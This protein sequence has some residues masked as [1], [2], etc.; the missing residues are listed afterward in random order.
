MS[1][2]DGMLDDRLKV[3]LD[4]Y[5]FGEKRTLIYNGN[6][7]EDVTVVITGGNGEYGRKKRYADH[8]NGLYN[9]REIVHVRVEDIG[10]EQPEQGIRFSMNDEE[11]GDFFNEY[12]VDKSYTEG[13]ICRIELRA[14][15]E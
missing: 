8:S 6:T 4:E 5:F 15:D 10:G 12:Y 13:G 9:V 14:V 7:Y 1:F 3:F 11:G 2:K